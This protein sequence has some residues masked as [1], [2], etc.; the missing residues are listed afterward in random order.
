MQFGLGILWLVNWPPVVLPVRVGRSMR[1]STLGRINCLLGMQML[2][3]MCGEVDQSV[4]MKTRSP[5]TGDALLIV[6]PTL[7]IYWYSIQ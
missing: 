7:R 6:D 5:Y 1:K 2:P 4:V 3:H